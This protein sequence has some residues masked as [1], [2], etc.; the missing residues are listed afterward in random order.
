[1]VSV[2]GDYLDI[3]GTGFSKNNGAGPAE[4]AIRTDFIVERAAK[5]QRRMD[6]ASI[7]RSV[8]ELAVLN[9][10]RGIVYDVQRAFVDVQA[11]RDSL[12][13]ARRNLE[14]LNGIVTV[15]EARVNSGDL[16]QVELVRSQVA[17]L[18]FRN[19][20]QQGELRLTQAKNQLR[21]L[22]GRGDAADF[23]VTGDMRR[24]LAAPSVDD[25][26]DQATKNRPDLLGLQKSQARSVTDLRLQL[27]YGKIGYTI[28]TQFHRQQSVSGTGSSM[29]FF[30]SFHQPVY[31]RNQGE[32]ERARREQ[33]LWDARIKAIQA[34]IANEVTGA[35]QQY[36]TS[37]R[38]LDGI[39]QN[40]L[41][42]AREVRDTTEYSYR[43]GE[44]TLVEFLD[45]QRAFNDTMQSYNEARADHARSLYLIDSIV[46]R[47]VN[48]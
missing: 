35:W 40:M 32:I 42:K 1:M 10:I 28:G 30:F 39:E 23:D 15:N 7:E 21:L 24:D 17:A 45:A 36:T 3:L 4:V 11:A 41:S 43:R 38:L 29:G 33:T 31:N 8:V 46:G 2:S 47:S 16:A 37:N 22:T 18:Q 48:P 19:A 25:L 26:R 34:R 12:D 14:Y 20:V 13:L 44:A 27:A 5:R 9:A 6:L